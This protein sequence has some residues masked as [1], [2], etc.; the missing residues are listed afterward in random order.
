MWIS[1]HATERIFTR[2]T[3]LPDDVANLIRTGN[4]VSLG[5]ANN[6]E[7]LL[8]FSPKE[9]AAKVAIVTL[10]RKKII[11]VLNQNFRLPSSIQKITKK[12]IKEVK[13][14]LASYIY[15]KLKEN[16]KETQDDLVT[17]KDSPITKKKKSTNKKKVPPT[18]KN[19]YVVIQVQVELN[20]KTEYE[21]DFETPVEVSR[22][23]KGYNALR[24]YNDEL[25]QLLSTIEE[26]APDTYRDCWYTIRFLSRNKEEELKPPLRYK[27]GHLRSFLSFL[28]RQDLIT[29]RQKAEEQGKK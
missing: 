24:L 9:Q 28:A 3:M 26:I 13:R 16:Y 14:L 22:F 7:Y 6:S 11:T 17:G 12:E 21:Q 23:K 5:F 27:H 18:P 1:N 8:F 20:Y 29:S 4:V 10:D 19:K 2:T 15:R 25:V